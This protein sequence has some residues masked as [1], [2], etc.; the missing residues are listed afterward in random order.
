MPMKLLLTDPIG[1]SECPTLGA[2][3]GGNHTTGISLPDKCAL[4][5]APCNCNYC[6]RTAEQIICTGNI[7]HVDLDG[8][9]CRYKLVL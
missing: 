9:E 3:F 8:M 1:F 5:A 4:C 7:F 6:G 2:I